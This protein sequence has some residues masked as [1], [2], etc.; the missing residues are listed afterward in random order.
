[1]H[2][3]N[4]DCAKETIRICREKGYLSAYLQAREKEVITM[5]DE[6]FDEEALREAYDK[7]KEKKE[8]EEGRKEGRADIINRLIK[9]GVSQELLNNALNSNV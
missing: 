9:A 6:L 5:L 4:I 2:G 3:K 7:A 1:M 8:R